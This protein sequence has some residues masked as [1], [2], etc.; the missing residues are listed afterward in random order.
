MSERRLAAL[1]RAAL[2]GLVTGSRRRAD[3]E[4]SLDELDG[5]NDDETGEPFG[6]IVVGDAEDDDLDGP[7]VD[8]S[9]DE[10]WAGTEAIK[11]E[12]PFIPAL[13]LD[14]G[15]LDDEDEGTQH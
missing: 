15:E 5:S 9:D 14:W 10:L 12:I 1:E 8:P 6:T 7:F 3:A 11:L 4:Q 13:D 2:V